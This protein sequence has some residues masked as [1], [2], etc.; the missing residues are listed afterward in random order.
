MQS[1]I[2][3]ED[4]ISSSTYEYCLSNERKI[5][6]IEW[7]DT[8]SSAAKAEYSNVVFPLTIGKNYAILTSNLILDVYNHFDHQFQGG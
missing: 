1:K 2:K 5:A 7:W 8:L 3:P 4:F 6:A